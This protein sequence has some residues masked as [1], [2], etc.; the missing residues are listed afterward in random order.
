MSGTAALDFEGHLVAHLWSCVG[1][2]LRSSPPAPPGQPWCLTC[3]VSSLPCS[4]IL[5]DPEGG[6]GNPSPGSTATSSLQSSLT[7]KQ[8]THP[9]PVLPVAL[10]VIFSTAPTATPDSQ[11]SGI[12]LRAHTPVPKGLWGQRLYLTCSYLRVYFQFLARAWPM[13]LLMLHKYI[14]ETGHLGS[15]I[16]SS[17]PMGYR[18]YRFSVKYKNF[19]HSSICAS[20]IQS[21]NHPSIQPASQPASY[22][23][24]RPSIH[25]KKCAVIPTLPCLFMD[26]KKEKEEMNRK[27]V[28]YDPWPDICCGWIGEIIYEGKD[29]VLSVYLSPA[30]SGAGTFTQ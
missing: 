27:W 7:Q 13:V 14:K 28:R 11:V 29:H 6:G 4:S 9:P 26:Y 5:P 30:A 15:Y 18:R 23:S 21:F 1:R 24:V 3:V 22:P 10:R 25:W 2:R 20:F 8:W 17:D 16:S 12:C 19:Y